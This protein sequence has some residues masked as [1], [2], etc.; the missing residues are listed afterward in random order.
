MDVMLLV[1]H[2]IIHR[3]YILCSA[4]YFGTAQYGNCCVVLCTTLLKTSAAAG[5]ALSTSHNPAKTAILSPK[6][7]AL[8]LPLPLP[9]LLLLLLLSILPVLLLRSTISPIKVEAGD[10]T[11]DPSLF[12]ALPGVPTDPAPA[13]WIRGVEHI[14]GGT[15]LTNDDF[16]TVASTDKASRSLLALG[17][18]SASSSCCTY[19]KRKLKVRVRV[20]V[21]WG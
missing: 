7:H 12:R 14:T 5:D 19:E 16:C 18:L 15:K 4:E 10:W 3:D 21:I 8:L 17:L 6:V 20:R 1:T 9:L 13:P 11:A 2:G